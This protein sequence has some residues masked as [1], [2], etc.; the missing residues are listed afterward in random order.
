MQLL[1]LPRHYTELLAAVDVESLVL[2]LF[3]LLPLLLHVVLLQLQQALH[4]E[5]EMA[6]CLLPWLLLLF[7]VLALLLLPL[8]LLLQ[9]LLLLLF[10][11]MGLQHDADY[12]AW[13]CFWANLQWCCDAA[14]VP[15]QAGLLLLLAVA[16]PPYLLSLH[17]GAVCLPH[18]Y[19]V[20]QQVADCHALK[21]QRSSGEQHSMGLDQHAACDGLH[22]LAAAC[23]HLVQEPEPQ[24]CCSAAAAAVAVAVVEHLRARDQWQTQLA[25]GQCSKHWAAG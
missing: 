10:W 22:L 17:S 18:Q 13:G 20:A 4:I 2:L 14:S 19:A 6:L 8:L 23:H 15:Y 21:H 5:H 9:L 12:P 11:A 1:T 3:L 7:L 24:Q 16:T 25:V